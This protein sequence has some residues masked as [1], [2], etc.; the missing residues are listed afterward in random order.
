MKSIQYLFF[1]LFS[2]VIFSS[3]EDVITDEISLDNGERQLTVDAWLNDQSEEQTI[4]LTLSQPYFDNSFPTVVTRATVQVRD[5]T[6]GEVFDF[7][8]VDRDGIYS[9]EPNT[10]GETLC[11]LGNTYTLNVSFAGETYQATSTVNRVPPIDSIFY[12]FRDDEF[13]QPDG[14]YA[15]LFAR[16]LEGAGDTYWIRTFKNGKYLDAT[17]E[18]N[19]AF[20]AGFSQGGNID[21]ITFIV[22]IREAI[23]PIVGGDDPPPYK[24]GDKIDVEIYSITNEAFFFFESLQIQLNNAGLFAE[25]SANVPTNVRN[26]NPNSDVKAVGYFGT[27]AVSR[28][29]VTVE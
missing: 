10:A 28:A 14:I 19:I 6:T 23:N 20:D 16:D 11:V 9:W 4:T 17:N 5:E 27:G 24:V 1:I 22:P 15:S 12:E 3:C 7:T 29:S 25:P 21:G 13:G 18:L 2:I 26:I 8:D